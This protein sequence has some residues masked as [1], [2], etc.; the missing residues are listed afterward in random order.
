M[1]QSAKDVIDFWTEA[2]PQLWFRGGDAFDD[3]CRDTLQ[4]LH[5]SAARGELTDWADSAEGSLAL[6]LLTDQIPRNIFRGSAHAYA[7][8]PLALAVAEHAI[9]KGHDQQYAEDLRS[10]FYMPFMHS[11]A[12]DDQERCTE[13]F[14]RL[15]GEN[16]DKWAWHHR[17]IIERFGRF[18]HR[19]RLLGRES[20]P[21][22]LAWLEE[23]GF[24]G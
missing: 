7:T 10:F 22:E 19:N 24:Q 9:A 2:G 17:G 23:G 4:A 6:L 20:T 3:K 14:G 18:P 12:P 13:L 15:S 11:E 16:A 1:T 8:D 5:F 21:E